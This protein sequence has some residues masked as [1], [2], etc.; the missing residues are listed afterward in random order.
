M[1]TYDIGNL[2]RLTAVFKNVLAGTLADPTAIE[3]RVRV[4]T[5][6][7][8]RSDAVKDK[9]G[10]YRI[11]VPILL[12]G[13]RITSGAERVQCRPRPKKIQCSDLRGISNSCHSIKLTTGC[14]SVY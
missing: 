11:D 7:V 4:G 8:A 5:T 13:Q 14:L 1:N 2:V 9:I 12:S 10:T 6:T 3:V